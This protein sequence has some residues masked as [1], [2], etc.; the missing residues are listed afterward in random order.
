M[1]MHW[2]LF[3]AFIVLFFGTA[4]A[5]VAAGLL[6]RFNLTLGQLKALFAV[7][8]LQFIGAIIAL[9]NDSLLADHQNSI[10]V[11]DLP[12]QF[13]TESPEQSL[14]SIRLALYQ[15]QQLSD[16]QALLQSRLDSCESNTVNLQDLVQQCEQKALESPAQPSEPPKTATADTLNALKSL[17]VLIEKHGPTVNLLWQPDTKHEIAYQLLTVLAGLGH[18]DLAPEYDPSKAA[19]ALTHY[20]LSE[21]IQPASG[22]LGSVSW[23]HLYDEYH[24]DANAR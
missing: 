5:T 12:V 20:Q 18:Y 19:A 6:G 7:L 15:Q 2:V 24:S 17:K 10:F 23:Q 14:K 8:I 1:T 16:A 9:N 3:L 13:Q 21:N 4:A 11:K 22:L